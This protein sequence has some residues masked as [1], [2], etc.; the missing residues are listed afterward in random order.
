MRTTLNCEVCKRELTEPVSLAGIMRDCG[1]KTT[2]HRRARWLIDQGMPKQTLLCE[3]CFWGERMNKLEIWWYHLKLQWLGDK[4]FE[5]NGG[6]IIP[7]IKCGILF[8]SWV[9]YSS[10]WGY[11]YDSECGNCE[12]KEV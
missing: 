8:K 9:H 5:K 10:L 1:E 6:G 12:K 2:P 4:E 3:K 7:C 11:S